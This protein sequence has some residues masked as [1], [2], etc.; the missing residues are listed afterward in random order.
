MAD[1][2]A[3]AARSIGLD[4][5]SVRVIHRY[6]DPGSNCLDAADAYTIGQGLSLSLLGRVRFHVASPHYAIWI[7]EEG[8]SPITLGKRSL[9]ALRL[10][11]KKQM[12]TQ[13]F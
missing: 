2:F 13:G 12:Y 5:E 7:C 1:P 11:S 4:E 9:T 8:K 10:T 3:R 6:I